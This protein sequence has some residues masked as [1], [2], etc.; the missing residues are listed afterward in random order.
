MHLHLLYLLLSFPSLFIHFT[1]PLPS[2]T[3]F[4]NPH[5]HIYLKGTHCDSFFPSTVGIFGTIE[6]VVLL[7]FLLSLLLLLLLLLSLMLLLALPRLVGDVGN[8]NTVCVRVESGRRG[9]CVWDGQ[10]I[11]YKHHDGMTNTCKY[12]HATSRLRTRS[13]HRD[14]KC[15]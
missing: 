15:E 11:V 6:A 8:L 13:E 4:P 3:L 10:T 9:V 5:T 1:F 2:S 12:Y 14:E 7:Y